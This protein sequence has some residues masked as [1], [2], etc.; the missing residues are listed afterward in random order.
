MIVGAC[1]FRRKR[2]KT[3]DIKRTDMDFLNSKFI[4][5]TQNQDYVSVKEYLLL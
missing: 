4:I 2:R 3:K 5:K 1:L